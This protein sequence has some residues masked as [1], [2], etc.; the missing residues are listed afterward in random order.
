MNNLEILNKKIISEKSRV[1]SE[2]MMLLP[3][4]STLTFGALV[5]NSNVLII[6]GLGTLSGLVYKKVADIQ[7]RR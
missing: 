7:K 2:G 3:G 1:Y 5:D 6:G 4:I